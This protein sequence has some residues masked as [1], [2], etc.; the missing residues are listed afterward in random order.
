MLFIITCQEWDD[1]EHQTW[2]QQKLFYSFLETIRVII[3][4][5]SHYCLLFFNETNHSV[6][7]G[8]NDKW[9]RLECSTAKNGYGMTRLWQSSAVRVCV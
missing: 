6:V 8:K 3:R 7:K 4:F 1:K 9:N 5:N 2:K